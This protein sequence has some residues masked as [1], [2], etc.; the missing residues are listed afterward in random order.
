[1]KNTKEDTM[2]LR[3]NQSQMFRNLI[4]IACIALFGILSSGLSAEAGAPPPPPIGCTMLGANQ[5]GE[6]FS[7]DTATGAGSFIGNTSPSSTEIEFD[8]NTDTLYSDGSNGDSNLYT[9]NPSTGE[10]VGI[11]G[12]PCCALNGMEY[13]GTTLYGTNNQGG[14]GWDLVTVDTVTGNFTIIG[15]LGIGEP[16]TGLA[17]DQVNGIMY[18]VTSG[19]GGGVPSPPQDGPERSFGN[20]SSDLVTIN[21]ATG[22]A[23]IIGPTG[24]DRVG[25]IEFG[26]NGILYGGVSLNGSI[27]PGGF[28]VRINTVTGAATPVGPSGF[29]SITGL[30]L[31]CDPAPPARLYG[32]THQGWSDSTLYSINEETGE[33]TEIGPIG[34]IACNGLDFD[35]TGS[36]YATCYDEFSGPVL[37]LIN[38]YTGEGSIVGQLFNEA[39]NDISF[40]NSDGLL[41]AVYYDEGFI[42]RTPGSPEQVPFGFGCY[43]LGTI[44]QT[45]GEMISIGSTNTCAPGNGMA[46]SAGDVLYFTDA[47]DEIQELNAPERVPGPGPTNMLY[48]LNQ[49]TGSASPVAELTY[50]PDSVFNPRINAMETDP[51]SGVLFA[52]VNDGFG[53]EGPNYLGTID[54]LTGEVTLLG[55]SAPGLSALAFFVPCIDND[56]DGECNGGDP[57]DDNDGVPDTDDSEPL[58][59]AACEDSDG[60][61]C[62]D[63]AFPVDGFGPQPDNDPLNDGTDIDGDGFCNVNDCNDFDLDVFPDAPEICDGLDNDCNIITLDGVDE[64]WYALDC[65]GSDADL[66]EEGSFICLFGFQFCTDNTNTN[67]E[68][69]DGIDND[70]D[71]IFPPE[72]TDDDGDGQ[73]ECQG[74]CDDNDINNWLGNAEVCDG[75]DNDCNGLDDVLGFAG[76]ET[77]NDG[78]GLSECQLDCDDND[79]NNFPGNTEVCDDQDSDCDAGTA[80]GSG[81]EWFGT[82]CDGP[83]SDLCDEGTNQCVNGEQTC[84]DTTN[85]NME[86]C[87]TVDNDCDEETPDGSDEEWYGIDCDGLDADLC[88]EGV[89]EC[90]GG[91]QTCSDD[92]GDNEEV[93]DLEDNDCDGETDEDLMTLTTAVSPVDAG[94]VEPDCSGEGCLYECFTEVD[95]VAVAGSGNA[96]DNW[97]VCDDAS[98]RFCSITMDDDI[99]TTAN[100]M[101][102][103]AGFNDVAPGFWAEDAIL[104][105]ACNNV[106]YGCDTDLGLYCPAQKVTRAELAAYIIRA[107]YGEDFSYSGIP[108]FL[109]VSDTYWGFRYI[110][111][112]YEDGIVSGCGAGNYCPTGLITRAEAS[113]AMVRALYGDSFTYNPAPY[114]SDV[115]ETHWAFMYIQKLVDDGVIS[116]FGDGTFRPGWK[117]T[118][119]QM[120]TMI[121][122]AFLGL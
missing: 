53:G 44:D 79:I 35:A 71:G 55:E 119:A 13:V 101:E 31:T 57:D 121:S 56:G 4:V 36:L 8:T 75:Q 30:T 99:D 14:G 90:T 82:D 113:V 69:C 77:D 76:S 59:P 120:A 116:G 62:D 108:H 48:V 81:E 47:Y 10:I 91:N 117:I 104:L 54:I 66:C 67:A 49:A 7:I 70:C 64:S 73:F 3:S 25:S 40:R 63:C 32:I 84:T 45:T 46:F 93:C 65:D 78:D 17:Y 43:S 19:G 5:F 11:L 24:L 87:D 38:L 105:A 33:A 118:R 28:V 61:G 95:L 97:S 83:D 22:A 6:L 68:V 89:F 39:P 23:T 42:D 16:V 107:L 103:E 58:N 9:I 18:G 111:R 37:V 80:D 1:M 115:P 2:N 50:P 52:A 122:K 109:D 98:D 20:G 102:C 72:E 60:D 96:F 106:V 15:P 21:L 114:F 26:E 94:V 92:T 85:D 112:M 88:E 34:F 27:L 74:D 100:F 29:A 51:E 12:H 86:I 41:H 110:Q